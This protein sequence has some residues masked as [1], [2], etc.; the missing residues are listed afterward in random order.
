[1]FLQKPDRIAYAEKLLSLD[2]DP[3]PRYVIAR[4][5]L[6]LD[7]AHPDC[8]AAYEAVCAHPYV[9][10]IAAAQNERGFWDPFHGTTEGNIRRLLSFGLDASHPTLARARAYL[11]RLSDGWETTGQYEKQDHP[12]WYPEMLE[13]LIAA[14]MLSLLEPDHPLVQKHRSVWAAFA[15]EIF[16]DGDYDEAHDIAVKASHFGYPV[17]RPIP[18]FNYYCLLLTAPV[19]G[20]SVLSEKTDRALVDFVMTKLPSLGYVYN[21]PPGIPI[22]IDTYRRDSRDFWHWVRALSIIA[23][24]RGFAAYEKT[25]GDFL[26]SQRNEGGLWTFPRRFDLSLSDRFA[27][28]HKTVDSSLFVLRILCGQRGY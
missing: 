27:G 24:Y 28:K 5:L 16:A 19:N 20:K 9:E 7:P 3:I 15:E 6:D 17:R 22:P 25:I 10:K 1:M 2:P 23:P 18:P 11:V 14:S 21:E 26:L 12:L 4:Q 8:R 13:P